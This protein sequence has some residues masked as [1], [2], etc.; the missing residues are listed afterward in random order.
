MKFETR[1]FVV[2]LN[3]RELEIVSRISEGEPEVWIQTQIRKDLHQR[4]HEAGVMVHGVNHPRVNWSEKGLGFYPDELI[5]ER[6]GVTSEA[7]KGAREVRGIPSYRQRRTARK[8]AAKLFA[9]SSE[10]V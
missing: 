1:N 6:L 8:Q 2:A 5:A 10:S 7:V 9:Q 4:A 3:S